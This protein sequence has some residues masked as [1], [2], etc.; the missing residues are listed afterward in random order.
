MVGQTATWQLRQSQ[1][2]ALPI[3]TL[4]EDLAGLFWQ[5]NRMFVATARRC[6][7][8]GVQ[9]PEGS[10]RCVPKWRSEGATPLMP[11]GPLSSGFNRHDHAALLE[12]RSSSA[13]APAS[14]PS[15]RSG[16]PHGPTHQRMSEKGAA[17][18]RVRIV[19]AEQRRVVL[20]VSGVGGLGEKGATDGFD[21]Q[22]RRFASQPVV[23]RIGIAR[24]LLDGDRLVKGSQARGRHGMNLWRGVS[25]CEGGRPCLFPKATCDAHGIPDDFRFPTLNR[26]FGAIGM[27]ERCHSSDLQSTPSR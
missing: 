19:G 6:R 21:L 1:A 11:I 15:V 20:H 17:H 23:D 10:H 7:N 27:S 4:H 24:E 18:G 22:Y 3:S 5:R 9:Q 25:T 2:T 13:S 14:S 12:L 8:A 16:A 26:R